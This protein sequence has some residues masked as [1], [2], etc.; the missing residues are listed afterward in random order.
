VLL[1][2]P[3][4][5]KYSLSTSLP[6]IYL[7]THILLCYVLWSNIRNYKINYISNLCSC[8]KSCVIIYWNNEDIKMSTGRF[9]QITT[10]ILPVDLLLTCVRL[11][12]WCFVR[13]KKKAGRPSMSVE[14][15]EHKRTEQRVSRRLHANQSDVHLGNFIPLNVKKSHLKHTVIFSLN[16]LQISVPRITVHWRNT[17]VCVH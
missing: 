17:K 14:T 4:K 12:A 5:L 7:V 11:W 9:S 6:C 10:R 16:I 1:H 8:L 13:H 2:L 3:T 15:V